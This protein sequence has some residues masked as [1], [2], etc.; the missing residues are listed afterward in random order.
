MKLNIWDYEGNDDPITIDG[1]NYKF[2]IS[3]TDFTY[4]GT[5]QG[6]TVSVEKV[7]DNGVTP[8]VGTK[9]ITFGEDG[10]DSSVKPTGVGT[11]KIWAVLT[12]SGEAACTKTK[13][14]TFSIKP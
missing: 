14:G 13:V 1:V 4:D 10:S 8:F 12:P 2:T 3:E 5:S 6:P 11:Y 7:I 9:V